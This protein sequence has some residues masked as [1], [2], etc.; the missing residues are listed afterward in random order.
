MGIS[1][2]V[3]ILG[4]ITWIASFS[5]D[6]YKRRRLTTRSLMLLTMYMCVFAVVQILNQGLSIGAISAAISAVCMAGATYFES[7]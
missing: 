6:L 2:C 5:F 1:D 4:S 3:L 7:K